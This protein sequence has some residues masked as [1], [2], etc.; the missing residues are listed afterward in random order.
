M[1]MRAKRNLLNLLNLSMIMFGFGAM[2]S[3][4]GQSV[5]VSTAIL[6]FSEYGSLDRCG[7]PSSNVAYLTQR[8]RC[9]S[10][11]RNAA[12]DENTLSF[13]HERTCARYRPKVSPVGTVTVT[14]PLLGSQ[15]AMIST[16]RPSTL[17]SQ[18]STDGT[19]PWLLHVMSRCDPVRHGTARLASAGCRATTFEIAGATTPLSGRD[20]GFARRS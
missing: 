4:H 12:L 13:A 8:S 10:S 3:R 11:I 20:G 1:G 9:S 15:C 18:M 7:K 2:P 17:V 19:S 16:N 14:E 5:A 6:R